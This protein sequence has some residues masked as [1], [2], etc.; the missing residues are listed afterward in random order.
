MNTICIMTP[1]FIF[2]ISM[3]CSSWLHP[4]T[5]KEMNFC[6]GFKNITCNICHVYF[7]VYFNALIAQLNAYITLNNNWLCHGCYNGLIKNR[8]QDSFHY[9]MKFSFGSLS[10]CTEMNREIVWLESLRT[11]VKSKKLFA[12]TEFKLVA[13]GLA[14]LEF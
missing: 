7:L 2:D 6:I 4:F 10:C 3:K 11:V 8:S 1:S 12:R 14:I 9:I 5:K 13:L